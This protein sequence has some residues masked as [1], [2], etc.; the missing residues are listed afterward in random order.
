[1]LVTPQIPIQFALDHLQHVG[2]GVVILYGARIVWWTRGAKAKAEQVY[3]QTTNHMPHSLDRIDRNI[4]ILV[5]IQG[6][7]A[8]TKGEDEN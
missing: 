6:G 7:T 1:M 5:G 3:T 8:V 2:W 4:A